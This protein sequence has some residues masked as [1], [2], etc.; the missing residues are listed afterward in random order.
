MTE[1]ASPPYLLR[2]AN[3]LTLRRIRRQGIILACCLWGVCVADFSSAG[4][5]DR[6][7]NIKFQD[8]LQFYVSA[9]LIAQGRTTQLYDE[10]IAAAE[11]QAIV[12]KPTRVRLPT[13]YGPQV[14]LY[15]VPLAR[16][17][18][19]VAAAIWVVIS[20][21]FFFACIY[22]V[23]KFC[24]KLAPH[25]SL[26]AILSLAFPPL[27]HFFVRGQ[28]SVLLL[29]CFTSAFL[30]FY[31]HHSLLAGA[32]L[33]LLIFK[34]QFLVAIPLIFLLAKSWR[35]FTGLIISTCTQLAATWLYF[36]TS[37]VRAYFDTMTHASRWISLAEPAQAHAQMHSLRSFWIMLFPWPKISLALY[38]VSA[39]LAVIIAAWSW[40][41]GGPL[42]LRFAALI[43]AAVL[44]NPHLFIYD[45]LV[46]AP[47]LL[48]LSEWCLANQTSP[49]S[50]A[51]RA[52][53]YLSFV[54]PLFGPLAIWTHLQLS[55]PAFAAMQWLLWS[56]LRSNSHSPEFESNP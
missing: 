13:V 40:R 12:Q 15:F 33:G 55:V 3:W 6:A 14:G 27:F 50:S 41:S 45:L 52:L 42:S 54:L 38:L 20:L 18:F 37:V 48:L 28:I 47:A 30:A 53:M 1:P 36:G 29:I 9:H 21:G 16:F 22:S 39:S 49:S 31:F 4:L 56:I 7:G 10:Q 11:M 34:P 26:I 51:L 46:L 23:C 5:F 43:F 2:L 24:P 19:S 8:F 32:A 17:S 35:P 25:R 44:A